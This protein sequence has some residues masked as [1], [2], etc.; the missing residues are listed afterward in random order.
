M[1][2]QK[3]G[4]TETLKT[5]NTKVSIISSIRTKILLLVIAAIV[6][7]SIIF[8]WTIVPITKKNL[9]GLNENYMK[10]VVI[11]YGE[12]L[13]EEIQ[14]NESALD[15]DNLKKIVGDISINDISS[16]YAY[17][18]GENGMMLYHPTEAKIGQPVEN[19]VI[20]ELSA[21]LKS[22]KMPEPAVSSYTFDGM[23]KY[24]AYYVG[25]DAKYILVISA[26]E[27]EMFTVVNFMVERTIAA[28]VFS[29]IIFGILGFIMVDFIV[30]P[31]NRITK[32]VT[33]LADMDFTHND[34]QEKLN[35]RRDETGSMSR[36]I[37]QLRERLRDIVASIQNQSMEIY[38]SSEALNGNARNTADSMGEVEKTVME[39]ADGATSQAQETQKAT[40]NVILMGNMVEE[41]NKEVASL[42]DNAATI[43]DS[44][45]NATEILANLEQI[46]EKSKE[47][48]E[49]IYE[50]TNTTNESAV[51]IREA[52]ALITAIAEETNLL[53]LNAAIEAARAGEQ[54][55]GFAV[56]AS[57]IQKLAEQSDESAKQIESIVNS[58][59]GDSE[60]AVETM[61]AV[62]DIIEQQSENVDKT[63][64]IFGQVKV[65]ID[66][67][68]GG[69][70]AI[71]EKTKKMD[72]ARINVVDIV[73]NLTA[74][75]EENAASTE[76]TS[77]SVSEVTNIVAN[78]SDNSEQLKE[79]SD[80]L[81]KHMEHFRL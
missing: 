75:A 12:L 16:S 66:Q 46:N 25:T 38:K 5:N 27:N 32:I 31:I 40:E 18:V 20:A 56:V 70:T 50:Q 33:K 17:V 28:G 63:N 26:D 10:D 81:E 54:G 53:S 6:L 65:G 37:S 35:R 24:S 9:T 68:I 14:L 76:E 71:A 52:T 36:A 44:S 72:E 58:L 64:V 77:A 41:T 80:R 19:E 11:A 61:N 7:T 34:V 3:M 23:V 67:S 4:E 2:K 30:K 29:L 78:I 43:R 55:R 13:D 45:N 22:G 1:E 47:A 48:I 42:R 39:I 8:L 79:I 69:I 15:G 51:K 21:E 62:R 59:I 60:K 73:Q 57:Q 49:I 74:I